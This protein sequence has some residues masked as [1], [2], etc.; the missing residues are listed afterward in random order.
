MRKHSKQNAFSLSIQSRFS[1]NFPT[2]RNTSSRSII[3]KFKNAARVHQREVRPFGGSLTIGP[4][5]PDA[6]K[7]DIEAHQLEVKEAYARAHKTTVDAMV[8]AGLEVPAWAYPVVS[9]GR[10]MRLQAEEMANGR[11]FL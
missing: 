1:D 2:S 10:E 9:P 11:C 7:A 4:A 6:Q 8:E 5:T 3:D